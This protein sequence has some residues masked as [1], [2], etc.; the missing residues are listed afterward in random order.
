MPLITTDIR[1]TAVGLLSRQRRRNLI[2][3]AKRP[4]GQLSAAHDGRRRELRRGAAADPRRALL[5]SIL[6]AMV[7]TMLRCY[8]Q[9]DDGDLEVEG[10]A[11]K[12]SGYEP[13]CGAKPRRGRPCHRSTIWSVEGK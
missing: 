6:K 11:K 3:V 5:R 4:V 2:R 1:S 8:E 7:P 10:E 12:S 9:L 13:R